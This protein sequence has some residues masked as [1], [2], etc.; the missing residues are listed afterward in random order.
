M[1]SRRD[2]L[3]NAATGAVLWSVPTGDNSPTGGH[4]NWSSPLI[5]GNSAYIGIA[6][7]GDCPL[8]AGQMLRVDLTTHAVVASVSFVPLGQVGGG[9]WSSPSYDAAT[10]T[11]YATLGNRNN[12]TQTIAESI[13]ALDGTTLAIKSN[14]QIPVSAASSDSDWGDSAILF[15]DGNNRAM[16]AGTDKNGFVYAFAAGRVVRVARKGWAALYTHVSS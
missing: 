3:K 14:W 16:V 7:V 11:V 15:T 8:V 5:V 4:Y 6:S 1:E 13:I 12:L 2:F 10:N 9:L